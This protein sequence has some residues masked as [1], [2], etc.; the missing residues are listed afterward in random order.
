VL[1]YLKK[2]TVTNHLEVETYT[3]DVLPG[4][5]RLE[6]VDS[7]VRELKWVQKNI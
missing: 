1:E 5:I 4:D 2:E 3:W 6:I 7:I